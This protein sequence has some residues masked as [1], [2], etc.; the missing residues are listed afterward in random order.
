ML[1]RSAAVPTLTEE[2]DAEMDNSER[3]MQGMADY[4]HSGPTYYESLAYEK[5]V[6]GRVY[7]QWCFLTFVPQTR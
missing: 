3:Y 1:E 4:M 2:W 5:C 6:D 7:G